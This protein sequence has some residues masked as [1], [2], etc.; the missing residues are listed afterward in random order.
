MD[1]RRACSERPQGVKFLVFIIIEQNISQSSILGNFVLINAEYIIGECAT[2]K[3][4]L[5]EIQIEPV[6]TSP[7]WPVHFGGTF[8][9][10]ILYQSIKKSMTQCFYVFQGRASES[11]GMKINIKLQKQ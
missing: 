11:C 1:A 7:T 10:C 9:P 8:G 2:F 3:V 6:G 4:G 5:V